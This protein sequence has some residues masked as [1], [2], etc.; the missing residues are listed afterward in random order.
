MDTSWPCRSWYAKQSWSTKTTNTND[1]HFWEQSGS[2]FF[3]A[4][5]SIT[6]KQF[7]WAWWQKILT[8]QSCQHYGNVDDDVPRNCDQWTQKTAPFVSRWPCHFWEHSHIL[9]ISGHYHWFLCQQCQ[10]NARW[11]AHHFFCSN[12]N[13]QLILMCD[14][15]LWPSCQGNCVHVGCSAFGQ[16]KLA[17]NSNVCK[18]DTLGL[19]H[20]DPY[21]LI[22]M[23]GAKIWCN[24]MINLVWSKSWY[25][26]WIGVINV[27]EQGLQ[28]V[29]PKNFWNYAKTQ[30]E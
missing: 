9:N 23:V 14:T 25:F 3:H 6:S 21:D 28:V 26:A 18:N 2:S 5:T 29:M 10:Q 13:N 16:A 27:K 11:V 19:I 7:D 22:D 24:Q 8:L 17:K 12:I 20:R 15:M 1:H 30:C 4:T